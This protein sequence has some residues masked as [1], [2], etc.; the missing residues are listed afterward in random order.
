MYFNSLALQRR[1]HFNLKADI[2]GSGV[3]SKRVELILYH[4]DT[5]RELFRREEGM[6]ERGRVSEKWQGKEEKGVVE[7]M[8]ERM[9]RE[10]RAADKVY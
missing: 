8:N 6:R 9:K 5:A 3:G 4:G 7:E 2:C 1:A 10:E